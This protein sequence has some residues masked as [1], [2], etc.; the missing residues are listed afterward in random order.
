MQGLRN[1]CRSW[2][3]RLKELAETGVLPPLVGKIPAGRGYDTIS[4]T[5]SRPTNDSRGRRGQRPR[6]PLLTKNL[7]GWGRGV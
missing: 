4:L 1:P 7:R 3:E 5:P 6:L 2:G